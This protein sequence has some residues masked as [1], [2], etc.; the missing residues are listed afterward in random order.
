MQ[1]T[2]IAAAAVGFMSV[3]ARMSDD[4]AGSGSAAEA[5][6]APKTTLQKLEAAKELVVKLTAKLAAENATN[7]IQVGD[8]VE[9]GFGRAEKR[10]ILKGTVIGTRID[11]NQSLWIAVATP[12][13]EDVFAEPA[14]NYRLRVSDIVRNEAAEARLLPQD[15]A[16]DPLNEAE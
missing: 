9:F 13:G 16:A 5:P 11:D 7:D 14:Q 15:E 2:L 6:K 10:R 8:A 3:A 12:A 4:N 1:R